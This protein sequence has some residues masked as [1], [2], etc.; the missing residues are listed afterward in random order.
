MYGWFDKN[1]N[2][3]TEMEAD[4]ITINSLQYKNKSGTEPTTEE[5]LH[6]KL[7]TIGMLILVMKKYCIKLMNKKLDNQII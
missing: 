5:K 6:Q 3:I 7:N 4:Y 1:P 2:W